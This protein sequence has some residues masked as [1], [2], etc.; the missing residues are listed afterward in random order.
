ML[1]TFEKWLLKI[2]KVSVASILTVMFVLVF[3]QV[4]ARYLFSV[5]FAWIDEVVGFGMIWLTYIG[6]GLALREGRL[7]GFDLIQKKLPASLER[8]LRIL[9]GLVI[10]LF[11]SA[12]IYWG[13]RF[14]LF[15]LHKETNVLQISR[16]IPYAGIPVGSLFLSLHLIIFFGRFINEQW[17]DEAQIANQGELADELMKD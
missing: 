14:S 8:G 15:G 17:D 9:L 12:L 1:K 11:M 5:S 2:N 4:L 13:I 10:L 16:A 6:A 3:S 7:V